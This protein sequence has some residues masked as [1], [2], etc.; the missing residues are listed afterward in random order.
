MRSPNASHPET[1]VPW[2]EGDMEIMGDALW[3]TMPGLWWGENF[4]W[5]LLLG[6]G[7]RCQ[8]SWNMCESPISEKLPSLKCWLCWFLLVSLL[9]QPTHTQGLRP[10]CLQNTVVPSWCKSR[11]LHIFKN[12][13]V[14]PDCPLVHSALW[15]TC[16]FYKWVLLSCPRVLKSLVKLCIFWEGGCQLLKGRDYVFLIF[17][18]L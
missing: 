14:W 13:T 18:F 2:G 8:M 11:S 12:V 9:P 3:V 4:C 15:W 17:I 7:Q 6:G 16:P 10:K 5:H 1:I